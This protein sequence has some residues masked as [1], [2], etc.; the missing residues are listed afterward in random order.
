MLKFLHV[1]QISNFCMFLA[2]LNH[3]FKHV[4]LSR[5][6]IVDKFYMSSFQPNLN[7]NRI[8]LVVLD[9]SKTVYKDIVWHIWQN[10]SKNIM[11][12]K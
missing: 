6:Y 10:L 5:L 3:D 11:F 1:A 12:S 8:Q 9:M 4:V 2:D 7:W